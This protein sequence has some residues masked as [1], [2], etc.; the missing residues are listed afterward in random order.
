MLI[1][2]GWE[3]PDISG[4][5]NLSSVKRSAS[6]PASHGA[7]CT[8]EEAGGK[9]WAHPLPSCFGQTECSPV[10][11]ANQTRTTRQRRGQANTIGLPPL[12]QYGKTKIGRPRTT[13][14]T[15]ADGARSASFCHPR[16]SCD[17]SVTSICPEATEAAIDADGWLHSGDSLRH[18]RRPADNCTVEG[19]PQRDMIIPR[20]R[21]PSTPR[22]PRR[23]AVFRHP[24]VGEK[25][26]S[27][28]FR[29]RDGAKRSA[30][31]IRPAP[32]AAH[33]TR[34]E[35]DCLHAGG[36]SAPAQGH[37]KHWFVVDAFPR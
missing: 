2:I 16:L 19:P 14:E 9:A 8:G 26:Q 4:E 31:F 3:H 22:E 7:G 23:A 12:P 29:M 6:R 27:S 37:Q 20:R 21:E 24:K 11:G 28:A 25:S 34:R 13:R 1:A 10:A 33:P 5:P 32:G 36:R 17:A 30:A 35:T 18:G 15:V